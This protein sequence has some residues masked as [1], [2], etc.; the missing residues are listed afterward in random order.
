MRNSVPSLGALVLLLGLAFSHVTSQGFLP[1]IKKLST[2]SPDDNQRGLICQVLTLS[3]FR[4][5][6][7]NTVFYLNGNDVRNNLTGNGVQSSPGEI[8]FN[9]TP[10]LEGCYT[11]GNA[12]YRSPQEDALK[13][14]CKALHSTWWD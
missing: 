4:V 2:P 5:P 11:C 1:E 3:G 7:L 14:V 10:D 12:T 9:I 8:I 13:L 6:V